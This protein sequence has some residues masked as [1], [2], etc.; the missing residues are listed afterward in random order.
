MSASKTIFIGVIGVGGVGKAFLGQLDFLRQRL[1]QQTPAI[2]LRL[3]LAQRSTKR[4]FSSSWAALDISTVATQL[5][6]SG[7][8]PPPLNETYGQLAQAPGRV[9]LVDNTSDA[10][11]AASYPAALQRGISIVTPNKK[12][13]SDSYDLWSAIF[14]AAANGTGAPS[15]GYIYHESTV[16]AGLPVLSTLREL[17]DTGDEVTRIEGVFSGTM[18]FLFNSFQPVGSAAGGAFA[19][20]V[21]KAKDLGYTEPDPRDDLN[22][23]DVARKLTILARIAGLKV[24]SPTAFPVQ[25]LI[26][27]ELESCTSGDDFLA[28]LP[29]FDAQMDKVKSEASAEGKVVR[30]VGSIDVAAGAVKVGLEKFD[31]SHPIAALKGSDNIINFYTKRYGN[32][33]LIVQGAGA[34]A[35]VTAMGVTGDLLKVIRALH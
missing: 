17:V 2:D 24:A 14:S 4:L 28:R 30:F 18:S 34:G 27:K 25:S 32:N 15:N 35:E 19:A 16:G 22:G 3:I 9:V 12:A 10:G 6:Q 5:D 23:L 31:T 13:F 26:P 8:P 21:K 11:L 7:T 1:A 29:E 20:E 33:P